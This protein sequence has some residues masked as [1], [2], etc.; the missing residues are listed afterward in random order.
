MARRGLPEPQTDWAVF[1]DFDG[2]VVELAR[3]PDAVT[4][5]PE[6]VG[7]L[8]RLAAVLDGA[9]A[10]VSGRTLASLEAML[11]D[12]GLPMAGTH[13]LER[14][15]SDGTIQRAWP[16]DGRFQAAR[17]ALERFV[18]EHPGTQWEDKGFSLTLHYRSV[19]ELAA[20][21]HALVEREQQRLGD[22]YHIQRGHYVIE[23]KPRGHDKGTAVAGFLEEEPFRG[24]TPVFVGDDVTD[25]DAFAVVLARDGHA[26]RVGDHDG[27]RATATLA[28][29]AEVLAWLRQIVRTLES[30]Q[31]RNG[32][33]SSWD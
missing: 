12:G 15:R 22:D 6:L 13:G 2:T 10:I 25:E 24:R 19:P 4:P 33:T 31:G 3:D 20:D 11:G 7:L 21:A 8:K 32:P 30:R 29:V 1:L 16:G 17:T 5:A 18:A 26:V 14:R 23:L 9:V 27:S 28:T